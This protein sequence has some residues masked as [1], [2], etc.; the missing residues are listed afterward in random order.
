MRLR[1]PCLRARLIF[2]GCHVRF[3]V[4][5]PLKFKKSANPAKFALRCQT[6]NCIF[7]SHR[8]D[9]LI[10]QTLEDF[11]LFFQWLELF[12]RISNIE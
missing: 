12:G 3:I 7:P 1:N 2:E 11:R 8:M 10:A 6:F 4:R 5:S 9:N